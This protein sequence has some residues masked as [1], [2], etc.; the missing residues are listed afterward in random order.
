MRPSRAESPRSGLR[1]D[2]T[3]AAAAGSPA[4]ALPGTT[5]FPGSNW[6]ASSGFSGRR[7]ER[8]G[9]PPL[10]SLQLDVVGDGL[11]HGLAQVGARRPAQRLARRLDVGYAQL[12]V[13]VVLAVV[14][15]RRDRLDGGGGGALA[16]RRELLGGLDHDLG[17]LLDGGA[18]VRVADVED[19]ARRD[20]VLVV[21]DAHQA[22]HGIVDE[23]ERALLLAAV[24]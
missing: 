4:R 21:D 13:L 20:S 22:V 19:A 10:R 1:P 12:Y 14:V 9:G 3:A 24:H 16:Q 18:V 17:Q 15:S 23:G 7:H 8:T 5:R 6:R 11:A 2:R